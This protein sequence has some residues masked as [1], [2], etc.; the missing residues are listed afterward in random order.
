MFLCISDICRTSCPYNLMTYSRKLGKRMMLQNPRKMVSSAL[1]TFWL[2]VLMF[3]KL[4]T[5]GQRAVNKLST[6]SFSKLIQAHKNQA[7]VELA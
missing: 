5:H 3:V 6:V 2:L 7:R 4:L 1:F